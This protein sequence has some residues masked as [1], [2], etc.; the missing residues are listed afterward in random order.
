M[1]I[2]LISSD[3]SPG[4]QKSLQFDWSAFSTHPVHG[5]R[6]PGFEIAYRHLYEEFGAQHEIETRDILVRRL[7]W[8]PALA[9]DGYAMLYE[10]VLVRQEEQFVAVRDHS[11]IVPLSGPPRAVVHLSHV[12]VAPR[13]RGSGLAGW[14]RAWPIQTARRC[15]REAGRAAAD[16]S[17]TLVAEM[18]PLTAEHPERIGRLK[19]YEKAGFLK[20]DPR[21]VDYLQPDFR[22][23]DEIDATA[24]PRPLR[25]SLIVRRVGREEQRAMSGAE[26]RDIIES[27]YAM[28]GREFR[29]LDM[30]AVRRQMQDLP[31]DDAIISLVPPSA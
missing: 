10:M 8:D 30:A 22:P 9:P 12:L 21:A 5:P 2:E 19:S 11:A 3:L 7:L 16:A 20:I 23:P 27:L 15:L 25:M 1:P 4:D 6:D 29:E 31:A 28:Y 24:G 18:E 13:W 17:I 26:V 14:M